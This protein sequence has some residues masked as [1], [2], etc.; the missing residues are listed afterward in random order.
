MADS[1]RSLKRQLETA[2]LEL[3]ESLK[4]ISQDGDGILTSGFLQENEQ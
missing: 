2:Q 4:K 1:L 3:T